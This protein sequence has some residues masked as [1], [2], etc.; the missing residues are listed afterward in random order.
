MGRYFDEMRRAMEWL[1][2]QP[3]T[4]FLGQAVGYPGTFLHATM[5]TVPAAKR[6]EFPVTESFQMQATLGLALA[7]SVP[8]SVY[9]RQN[10]LM[11]AMGDLINMV[12][13][14]P[15]ISGG[16]VHPPML[17]RTAAG[18]T[19]PIHPGHQH[20]GH[21][22]PHFRELLPNVQVV[23]LWEPEHI[24]PAYQAAF[25]SRKPAILVEFGDFYGD[26]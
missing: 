26:K 14:L 16:K 5:E 11:L 2:E 7:G 3:E 4:G 20:V 19:K 24:V 12:D 10:F 13:K 6:L 21:L 22:A 8:V 15:A 23:E 1:G 17:I 25:R 18:T 9:P